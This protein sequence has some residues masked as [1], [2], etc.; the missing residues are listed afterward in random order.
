LSGICGQWHGRSC[1][2]S[3]ATDANASLAALVHQMKGST[4]HLIN[5]VFGPSEEFH[6]QGSY[7]AFSVDR[8]SI[9]RVR[10]Y[11]LKQKEH[12]AAGSCV[13]DWDRAEA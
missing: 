13:D 11:V 8:E 6:W 9:D 7:A 5:Y 10:A 12:H 2:C 4:S 3:V 1:S